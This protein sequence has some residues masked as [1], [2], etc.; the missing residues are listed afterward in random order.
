M[1]RGDGLEGED[2]TANARTI[3]DIP[4]HLKGTRVPAIC[5]VRG[6]VYMTKSAFLKL[7]QAQQAGRRQLFANPRNAAAGSLRQLDPR[8]T[9][10]R[11]LRFFAYARGR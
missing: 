9:A 1:T 4:R 10:S 5:E 2:V 8:I 7:N 3:R 6:E 11:P